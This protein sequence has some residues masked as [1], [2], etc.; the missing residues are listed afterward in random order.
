MEWVS[1]LP[2]SLFLAVF[3]NNTPSCTSLLVFAAKSMFYKSKFAVI[4]KGEI[5]FNCVTFLSGW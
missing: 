4:K 1:T 3:H 2:F 5:F